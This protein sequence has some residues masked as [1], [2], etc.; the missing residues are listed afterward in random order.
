MGRNAQRVD[1][2]CRAKADIWH[3]LLTGYSEARMVGSRALTRGVQ[4]GIVGRA[5]G[6]RTS[7]RLGV[8]RPG[9]AARAQPHLE[10]VGRRL[11][12]THGCEGG[13][14]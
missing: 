2:V 6:D 5:L 9:S 10:G 14:M 4:G 8:Q 13:I 1:M 7:F 12:P 11:P 3:R